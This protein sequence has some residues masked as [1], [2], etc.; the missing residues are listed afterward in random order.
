MIEPDG[1]QIKN[2]QIE[3]F[4]EF[5]NIK[6]YDGKFKVVLIKDADKM[7]TSSQNRILKTLEE[8]P[9]DVIIL[10]ITNNSEK[11]LPTVMSRCQIIK[12]NNISESEIEGYLNTHHAIS[13]DEVKLIAKLSMGSIGKANDYVTSDVF[14]K[15]REEVKVLLMAIDQ[16]EKSKILSIS[17]YMASEKDNISEILDYMILWYRDILLYKKAKAKTLLVHEHEFELIKKLTRNLTIKKIIQNIETIELT[18]KKLNQHG[19][20]DLT[21][22]VMLIKLLEA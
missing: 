16:N 21:I 7:N 6:A 1:K 3:A 13:S 12:L 10:M 2:A 19:H 8:P 11:F 17:S 15:I 14:T 22:E 4:Q 9:A 18:K 20:F 5:L